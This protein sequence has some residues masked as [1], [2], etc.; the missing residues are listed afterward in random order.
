MKKLMI[1]VILVSA[2][3]CSAARADEIGDIQQS[4]GKLRGKLGELEKLKREYPEKIKDKKQTE[5]TTIG[6]EYVAD[7]KRVWSQFKQEAALLERSLDSYSSKLEADKDSRVKDTLLTLKTTIT[8]VDKLLIQ[9]KAT[10]GIT[11]VLKLQDTVRDISSLLPEPGSQPGASPTSTGRLGGT[12]SPTPITNGEA[13]SGEFSILGYLPWAFVLLALAGLGTGLFFLNRRVAALERR[14]VHQREEIRERTTQELDA[15]WEEYQKERKLDWR[16]QDQENERLQREI[17]RTAKTAVAPTKPRPIAQEASA[18]RRREEQVTPRISIPVA[19]IPKI[20]PASDYLHRAGNSAIRAK[21]VM[22]RPEVLQQADA[23]GPYVLM[24]HD[25]SYTTYQVI[26]GV[27]RFQ[28]PQD[29]SHFAYFYECEQ[30]SSGELLIVEPA[31]ATYDD[32]A[33][34]WTLQRKGRLQIG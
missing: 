20:L 32:S 11:A 4:L 12:K 34:Q 10:D 29:Y 1:W 14:V 17:E 7:T 8:D 2:C 6:S 25:G 22:F 16:Q 18:P 26:P 33:R 28:S 19:T 13:D 24:L 21:A 31:L 15:L 3:A 9:N 5:K 27:P 30:P 23:D